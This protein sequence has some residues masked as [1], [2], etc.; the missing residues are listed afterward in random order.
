MFT[1]YTFILVK[2]NLLRVQ[3]FD[4]K[5]VFTPSLGVQIKNK[6][7]LCGLTGNQ[8]KVKKTNITV[9]RIAKKR[10]FNRPRTSSVVRK[11]DLSGSTAAETKSDRDSSDARNNR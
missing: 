10:W 6:Y 3:D 11:N 2:T 4:D 8:T 9:I 7:Y 1:L 5:M